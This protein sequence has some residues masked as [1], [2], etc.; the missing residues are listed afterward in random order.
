M[1]GAIDIGYGQLLLS[2]LFVVLAGAA[3]LKLRLGLERDLLWGTLR[4]VAQLALLAFVLV[5]VFR[6][7]Q[8]YLVVAIYL[9]MI[10]FA[11]TIIRGRIKRTNATYVLPTFL[12]MAL[13]YVLI[14]YVVVGVIVRADP[15]FLPM[16][17]IPIGGM[18]IGNSMNAIAIALDRLFSDLLARRA[19]VELRLCLGAT[20][21]EASHEIVREAVRAGM[22]PSINAMMGVGI[23]F[24]PGMMTGQILAGSDPIVAVKYQIMVM[25]MLVG[26]TALGSVLVVLL[27]RRRCFSADHRLILEERRD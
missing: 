14:S 18:I 24:I 13:S 16:Y 8:W 22:I 17:F 15:W 4:S 9:M 3:S 26:S 20:S 23:V 19:Q 2:L 6:I 21:R 7:E 12:S 10:L 5:Y 1:N 25:L 27:V 11:A